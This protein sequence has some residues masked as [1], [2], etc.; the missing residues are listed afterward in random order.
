MELLTNQQMAQADQITVSTESISGRGL[1]EFELLCN[2]GNE[3][4]KHVASRYAA[5]QRILVICGI[6]NNGGDGYIAA[7]VLMDKG[8]S[9]RLVS[10]AD[11]NSVLLRQA[12]DYWGQSIES[13]VLVNKETALS[14]SDLVIDA[15]FGAGLNR[16][17][18]GEAL[19]WIRAL[20]GHSVPVVAV[21]VPSG[22]NADTG[23]MVDG[24]SV[25]ATSTITF[26]RLKPGHILYP[27]RALCGDTNV[28]DIG[29][30]SS[31]LDTIKP[32]NYLNI[33]CYWSKDFPLLEYSQNKFHRG[34]TV[35]FSGPL[36]ATGAARLSARG[37]LR[38]G[39]GLVTLA[40]PFDAVAVVAAQLTAIMIA[41]WETTNDALRLIDDPRINSVL[42]GPGFGVGN[43]VCE[44]VL[45]L[46]SGDVRGQ[47]K[48]R[49]KPPTVV[50]DAD[51]LTSFKDRREQLFN[52]IANY[53]ADVIMTPHDGEYSR[54]FECDGSRLERAR[55]ASMQSGA[56]VVLKGTDTVVAAPDGTATICNNAPPTLATAGSGDVLAGFIAGLLAQ[57][58]AGFASANAA[59]WLHGECANQFGRGLIAEDLAEQLPA[60]LAT[61]QPILQP[62]HSN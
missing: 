7:R 44:L 12:H 39:S 18:T 48:L 52:A 35:V 8:Y 14:N 25:Q 62:T 54:L 1:T 37:S 38:V 61:L 36:H 42:I 29:I 32:F 31:V 17:L 26:F 20:Q 34:H 56:I 5:S 16:A 46:L 22:L 40:A 19:A 50:L 47:R 4:A 49:S 57:D 55:Y 15:M 21:D 10:V 33:P 24:V 3:V 23:Q 58:M 9:V 28:V 43:L 27:G 2:A 41:P 30:D 13:S 6:G 60:V 59:V 45:A 11:G 51:A 53:D